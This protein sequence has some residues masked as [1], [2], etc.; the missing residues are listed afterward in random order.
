MKKVTIKAQVLEVLI[1][2]GAKVNTDGQ[3]EMTQA[4]YDNLI[5]EIEANWDSNKVW[6]LVLCG[7]KKD[8][9]LKGVY[10]SSKK[11]RYAIIKI[12]AAKKSK[13][14]TKK[15]QPV[16][17]ERTRKE[18]GNGYVVIY[19]MEGDKKEKVDNKM[20][21]CAEIKAFIKDLH[22]QAEKLEMLQIYKMGTE[23]A[24]NKNEIIKTRLSAWR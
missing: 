7:N 12:V 16:D 11:N 22:H 19:K 10:D 2:L 23:Y 8:E 24:N 21:T 4:Q 15:A 9:T 14:S 20:T 1:S 13:K 3:Y 17:G 18:K 5:D 6:Q